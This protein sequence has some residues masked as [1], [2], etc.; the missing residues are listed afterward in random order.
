MNYIGL[1]L[2]TYVNDEQDAFWCLVYIMFD[3]GW[4][5][6]FTRKSKLSHILRDLEVH[7]QQTFPSLH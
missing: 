7:L 5:D 6:I 4:R 1:V 2:L 3:Q